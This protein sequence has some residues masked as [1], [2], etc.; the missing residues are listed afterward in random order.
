MDTKEILEGMLKDAYDIY[1]DAVT[2]DERESARELVS[3]ILEFM[4]REAEAHKVE[5]ET[6]RI[7][8][9]VK[10]K[11]KQLDIE[12]ELKTKEIESRERMAILEAPLKVMGSLPIGP[13]SQ[14][15]GTVT[16]RKNFLDMMKYEDQGILPS[17]N[18]DSYIT[19]K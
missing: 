7:E 6:R 15:F 2:S 17:R 8:E 5:A 1:Q 10:L 16:N 3:D 19:K 14:I 11:K 13:V 12:V 18:L 9:E 4:K